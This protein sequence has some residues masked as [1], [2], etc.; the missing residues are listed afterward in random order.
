[1]ACGQ[2]GDPSVVRLRLLRLITPVGIFAFLPPI[3]IVSINT[4]W[5]KNGRNITK[6][7]PKWDIAVRKY[8]EE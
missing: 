4:S 3:L 8:T 6:Y 7:V 1:M 2:V 5:T